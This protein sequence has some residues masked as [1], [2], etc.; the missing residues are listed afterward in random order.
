MSKI[1]WDFED[2]YEE[3]IEIKRFFRRMKKKGDKHIPINLGENF[4]SIKIKK[5]SGDWPDKMMYIQLP[6]GVYQNCTIVL[7]DGFVPKPLP[8]NDG[9]KFSVPPEYK[10]GHF[11]IKISYSSEGN[12]K[13]I[14]PDTTVTIGDPPPQPNTN[15]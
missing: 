2:Q 12:S 9:K 6:K 14:D 10:K 8:D 11:K 1:S 3:K 7:P 5:K 13:I 15:P 4:K